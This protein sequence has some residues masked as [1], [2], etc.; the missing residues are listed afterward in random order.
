[1][2]PR[3]EIQDWLTAAPPWLGRIL[4][5]HIEALDLLETHEAE[6]AALRQALMQALNLLPRDETPSLLSLASGQAAPQNP[7]HAALHDA[8]NS[9][10]G[11]SLL[12]DFNTLRRQH[13]QALA[14]LS[15]L[16]DRFSPVLA[17]DTG[18]DEQKNS[19]DPIERAQAVLAS[20]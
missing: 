11:N 2:I 1:L 14:L 3:D 18:T 5:S 8:L 15:A 13:A 4:R 9:A 12:Q 20:G 16:L 7:Q 17:K 19:P 10:A 6:A